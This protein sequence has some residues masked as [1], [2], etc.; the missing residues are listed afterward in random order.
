MQS[1]Y[2]ISLITLVAL[3]FASC[4]PVVVQPVQQKETPAE[5]TS[6]ITE[7]DPTQTV[8]SPEQKEIRQ[9]ETVAQSS[10]TSSI[11]TPAIPTVTNYPVAMPIPGKPG[12]VYNPYNNNPVYV[13]GIASGKIVRDPQDPNLDHKFRV[14]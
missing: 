13:Q 2:K 6:V 7:V 4:A 9:Q 11:T 12:Y 14:P 8:T 10:T 5:D 3:V 1:H